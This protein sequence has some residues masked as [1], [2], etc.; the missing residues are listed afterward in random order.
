MSANVDSGYGLVSGVQWLRLG[1]EKT[2]AT[3][4]SRVDSGYGLVSGRQRLRL[5]PG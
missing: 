3:A 1:L 4:G 5:G 2:V